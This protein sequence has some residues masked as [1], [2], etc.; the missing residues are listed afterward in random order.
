MLKTN[1][2]LSRSKPFSTFAV[3]DIESAKLF[4]QDKLGLDVRDAAMSGLIEIHSP[5]QPPVVVYPNPDHQPAVFTVLNF[6][7]DDVDRTVDEL[8][9][10]GVTFERYDTDSMKTDAKGIVRGQGPDIAWFRDPA[11]NILSVIGRE[12]S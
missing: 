1:T 10:A 9:A 4:Y 11:G 12:S 5:G 2:T 3:K 7:V 8:K 6:P